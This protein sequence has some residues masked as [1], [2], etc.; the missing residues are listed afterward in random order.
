MHLNFPEVRYICPLCFL[1]ANSESHLVKHMGNKTCMKSWSPAL[2]RNKKLITKKLKEEQARSQTSGNTRTI[3]K[4]KTILKNNDQ[5]TKTARKRRENAK[6]QYA[7]KFVNVNQ[8]CILKDIEISACSDN[9]LEISKLK[10]EESIDVQ[11]AHDGLHLH[12]FPCF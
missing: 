12:N 9:I 5:E 3:D 10:E 7:E 6:K 11:L 1:E 8:L 4:I 2:K